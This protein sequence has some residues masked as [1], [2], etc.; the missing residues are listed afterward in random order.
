V[1]PEPVRETAGREATRS[2]TRAASR[3]STRRGALGPGDFVVPLNSVNYPRVKFSLTLIASG[4]ARHQVVAQVMS[5]Y[6]VKVVDKITGQVVEKSMTQKMAARIVD[7]AYEQLSLDQPPPIIAEERERYLAGL[8]LL[9]QQ[10][11]AKG[12]I[13]QARLL[14]R[15]RALCCGVVKTEPGDM[16]DRGPS[17]AASLNWDALSTAEAWTLQDLLVRAAQ[18]RRKSDAGSD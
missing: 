18:P 17:A 7:L 10:A 3:G 15:D 6:P 13:A 8:D 1:E 5:K 4:C 12:N 2:R 11:I 9:I 14:M 16:L